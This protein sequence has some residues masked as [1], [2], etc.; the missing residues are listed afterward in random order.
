MN[1]QTFLLNHKL[2]MHIFLLLIIT[3]LAEFCI[4]NNI[5]IL[6]YQEPETVLELSS[7]V[8]DDSVQI[9]EQSLVFSQNASVEISLNKPVESKTIYLIF[10]SQSQSYVSGK[11]NIIDES[12]VNAY[13][14]LN[15]FSCNPGGK[16]N[17]VEVPLYS[18]GKLLKLQIELTSGVSGSVTL[19]SVI[20]NRHKVHFQLIRWLIMVVFVGLIYYIRYFKLSDK[21]YRVDD[22]ISNRVTDILWIFNIGIVIFLMHF[23]AQVQEPIKYPLE[24]EPTQY[25][26]MVQQFDALQKGRL[27]LDYSDASLANLSKIENPYDQTQRNEDTNWNTPYWDHVYYHGKI[28]SYFGLAPILTFYYPYYWCTKS[29]PTDATT[30]LF[31]SLLAVTL[32]FLLIKKCIICFQ[33]KI[34]ILDISFVFIAL[35]AVSYI[36]LIQGS[37]DLYYIPYIAVNAF[38]LLFLYSSLSAYGERKTK[39]GIIWYIVSG[40]A[41]GLSVASRPT[42]VI[43]SFLLILPLYLHVLLDKKTEK[44]QKTKLV[45]GFSIPVCIIAIFMMWYNYA[46]FDSPFDFGTTNQLTVSDIH[47][48][49]LSLSLTRIASYLY[50]YW[51]MPFDFSEVFPFIGFDYKYS[52]LSGKYIWN[53]SCCISVFM[54]PLN[55]ALLLLPAFVHFCNPLYQKAML[56]S[57]FISSVIILYVDFCLGGICIR[58]SCD[59]SLVIAMLSLA[60]M[61]FLLQIFRK[62]KLRSFVYIGYIMIIFSIIIAYLMLFT[63]ER[64]YIR[65]YSPDIFLSFK[66]LFTIF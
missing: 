20:L 63:N 65:Q 32:C 26:I 66:H 42:A 3:L 56:L 13:N 34:S 16:Y 48:N 38:M 60:I 41:L 12:R 50:Q 43:P 24:N 30:A 5:S 7:A 62:Y 22:Y 17:E 58:Y 39:K 15:I 54:L 6:L 10:D 25:S 21:I 37:A 59:I 11:I 57:G 55:F 35:P 9:Q 53:G 1:I 61:C 31:F 40:L 18:N 2:L 14:T 28:Y 64:N 47:Y 27:D 51:F 23:S 52:Y 19:C 33:I 29:L 45:A 46:R 36:F 49:K 8:C 44:M 4:S